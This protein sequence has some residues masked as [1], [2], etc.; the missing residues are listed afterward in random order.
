MFAWALRA[1]QSAAEAMA[2]TF[3]S[4]VLI[5]FFTA[6]ALRS[7]RRPVWQRPFANRWL[8]LAV[9]WELTLLTVIFYLPA[10][11]EPFGTFQLRPMDWLVAV[12]AAATIL[13]VLEIAK[14]MKTRGWFGDTAS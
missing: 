4:L 1:R 12:T 13:P 5:Q 14:W 6:Y 10:L 3:L 11:Q 9:L 2:L 7:D 8:N